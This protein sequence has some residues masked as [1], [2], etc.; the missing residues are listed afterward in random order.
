MDTGAL[1]LNGGSPPPSAALKG[2]RPPRQADQQE[3]AVEAG[4]QTGSKQ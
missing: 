1:V 2:L 3:D 4:A